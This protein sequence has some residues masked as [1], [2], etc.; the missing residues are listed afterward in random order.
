MDKKE[1]FVN[2]MMMWQIINQ[3]DLSNYSHHFQF[4]EK[5]LIY[6]DVVDQIDVDVREVMLPLVVAIQN[7]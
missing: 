5:N 4:E 6:G 7:D 1:R 3:F 2:D